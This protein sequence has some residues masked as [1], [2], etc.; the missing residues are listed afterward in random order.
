M[1][2]EA[3]NDL[4]DAIL[5]CSVKVEVTRHLSVALDKGRKTDARTETL[6]IDASVTPIT[7]KDMRR[8]GEGQ[9]TEGSILIITPTELLTSKSSECRIPDQIQ[10][11]DADYQ[12][13]IV[14]DWFDQGGFFECVGLRLNR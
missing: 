12:I 3:L 6:T 10:Y 9:I 13:D 14:K 4:S 1:P 11:R 2:H 8:L 5:D 7:G